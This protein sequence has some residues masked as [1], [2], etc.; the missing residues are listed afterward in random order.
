MHRHEVTHHQQSQGLDLDILGPSPVTTSC[1]QPHFLCQEMSQLTN[2]VAE[3][4]F[5]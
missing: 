4:S 1:G 2:L 5:Y 3:T